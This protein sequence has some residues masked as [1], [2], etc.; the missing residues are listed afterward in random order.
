M[1]TQ[2]FKSSAILAKLRSMWLK[3][4]KFLKDIDIKFE[5]GFN[6]SKAIKELTASMI[7]EEDPS[8]KMVE[9]LDKCYRFRDEK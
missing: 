7:E 1:K 5:Q 6:Y 8:S 4:I 9:A 2:F 3:I